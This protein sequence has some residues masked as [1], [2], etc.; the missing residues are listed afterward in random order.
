MKRIIEVEESRSQQHA[1]TQISAEMLAGQP[2]SKCRSFSS[3]NRP[4]LLAHSELLRSLISFSGGNKGIRPIFFS[5]AHKIFSAVGVTSRRDASAFTSTSYL[6]TI[7][8]HW[9]FGPMSVTDW[10]ALKPKFHFAK[11]SVCAVEDDVKVK[12]KRAIWL[13]FPKCVHREQR[14]KRLP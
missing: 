4:T 5:K 1:I 6:R 11:S 12:E 2:A 13:R 9:P 14:Q 10:T 3:L 7:R 8:Q